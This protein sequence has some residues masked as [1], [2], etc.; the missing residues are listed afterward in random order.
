MPI[1]GKGSYAV[2]DSVI[3]NLEEPGLKLYK[4]S[5]SG[6]GSAVNKPDWYPRGQGLNP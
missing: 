4:W 2:G 5:S 6:H 3:E 1:R